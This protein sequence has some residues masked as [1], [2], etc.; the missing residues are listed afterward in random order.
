[1]LNPSSVWYDWF[2]NYISVFGGSSVTW[3]IHP[4]P[5][6][7]CLTNYFRFLPLLVVL[8]GGWLG[9]EETGFVFGDIFFLHLL[10]LCDIFSLH[11]LILRD[12]FPL[13]LLILC[14]IFS[15]HLLILCDIFS[16]HLL[17]LC[18]IFPFTC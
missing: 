4:T 16:L 6:V 15:L 10:I 1:M 17:I 5:S 18:D 8:I 12:I 14:D 3:L 13:H 9:Y 7:I 2:T 11:L